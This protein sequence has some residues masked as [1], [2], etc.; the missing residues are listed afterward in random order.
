MLNFIFNH[1]DLD[2]L[3]MSTFFFQNTITIIFNL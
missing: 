1:L 3:E 2:K